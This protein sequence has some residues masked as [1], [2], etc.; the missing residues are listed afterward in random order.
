MGK[1][2]FQLCSDLKFVANDAYKAFSQPKNKA[3][4]TRQKHPIIGALLK[5]VKTS[6]LR[7]MQSR[8]YVIKRRLFRWILL[9][10]Y[11]RIAKVIELQ[12][13]MK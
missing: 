7:T 9:H 3:E 10:M 1:L 4:N 2:E 6:R 12:L 5:A 13:S 11:Y 8:T